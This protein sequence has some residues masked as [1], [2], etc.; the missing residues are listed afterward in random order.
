M[1]S[2]AIEHSRLLL[3]LALLL[4]LHG[5]KTVS[6]PS[7]PP[8]Q[9]AVIVLPPF[10][11]QRPTPAELESI[12]SQQPSID[13]QATENSLLISPAPASPRRLPASDGA[14]PPKP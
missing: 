10:P 6:A 7:A 5:C 12:N 3:L 1:I 9:S 13:W 4:L 11:Y 8:Q 2:A 14:T